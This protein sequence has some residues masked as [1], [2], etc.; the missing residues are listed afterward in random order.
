M[1]EQISPLR[2]GPQQKDPPR[3]IYAEQVQIATKETQY[4]IALPPDKE[5]DRIP[6]IRLGQVPDAEGLL[7]GLFAQPEHKG[8]YMESASRVK[9]PKAVGRSSRI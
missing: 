5:A 1:R 2:I 3:F 8:S 7:V 9:K 6:L 4:G